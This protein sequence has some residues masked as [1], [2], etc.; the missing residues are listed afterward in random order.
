MRRW[1][2]VALV[3]LAP[4]MLRAQTGRGNSAS[5][6]VCRLAFALR[7]GQAYAAGRSRIKKGNS[8]KYTFW[9]NLRWKF[10]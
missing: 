10:R 1:L 7:G 9:E 6:D 4:V 3:L 8:L 2:A 5:L